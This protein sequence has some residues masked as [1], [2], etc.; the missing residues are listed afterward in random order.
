M[1]TQQM[2]CASRSQSSSYERVGKFV[3]LGGHTMAGIVSLLVLHSAGGLKSADSCSLVNNP[4]PMP[5]GGNQDINVASYK[6]L[7]QAA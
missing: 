7:H 3:Q 2:V 4:C 6:W 5:M 1:T